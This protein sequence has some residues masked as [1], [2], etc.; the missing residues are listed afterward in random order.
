MSKRIVMTATERGEL[1][2]KLLRKEATAVQLAREA[3]IS[4]PTSYQW[5]EAFLQGGFSGLEDR[6]GTGPERRRLE[7]ELAE[8]DQVIG[9][10]TVA[11]R[12]LKKVWAYPSDRS[13]STLC[14][15]RDECGTRTGAIDFGV[16]SFGYFSLFMVSS[17]EVSY[18][19]PR[20]PPRTLGPGPSSRYSSFGG[21]VSLLGL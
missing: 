9:E 18:G 20:S 21:T 15:I 16:V 2:L 4:E 5:R 17:I 11:L 7:R 6:R 3:G 10:M 8:R 13:F 1:V 12:T 19:Y 14:P